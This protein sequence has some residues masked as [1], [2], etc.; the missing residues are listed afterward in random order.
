MNI[1]LA[2]SAGFCFGVQRAINII[3]DEID[4]SILY[5]ESNNLLLKGFPENIS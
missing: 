2:K 5:D 1:E 4:T 3:Y